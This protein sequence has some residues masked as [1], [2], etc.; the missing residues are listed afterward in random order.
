MDETPGS[1]GDYVVI[2]DDDDP[3]S[4]P[5]L[6]EE[7]GGSMDTVKYT[8]NN[9]L[10]KGFAANMSS[11]CA[12]RLSIMSG[13]KE[14]ERTVQFQS[15]AVQSNAP[16]GLERVSKRGA[17]NSEGKLE[18]GREFT[19][20]FDDNPGEG[21]DIYILDTGVQ[22]DHVDFGGRA[23]FGWAFDDRPVDEN[24][25]GTHCAG[26]AASTNFGVAKGANII[27]VKVLGGDGRGGNDAILGGIDFVAQQHA[28]RKDQP[29]F[30]GSI[31]SMSL[32]SE[33]RSP[34][35]DNAV[36]AAALEG[37]HVSVA[38]GNA[39]S[40]A[41]G[42]SPGF[43]SS[44]S[45]VISVGAIDINDQRADFSNFGA[46]VTTYAPGFRILS[47]FIDPENPGTGGPRNVINAISGTSMAC[48]HVTGLIAYY[49]N[50]FPELATDP[51]G[52]KNLIV[53]ASEPVANL[54]NIRNDPAIVVTNLGQ[55]RSNQQA[56]T[57]VVSNPSSRRRLRGN[58][59]NRRATQKQ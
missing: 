18:T 12:G 15:T 11:H 28:A 52:M 2:V 37:I 21:V 16:W 49:L 25:H 22:V 5:E 56:N 8:Y 46:C 3:R 1:G 14:Y 9:T 31:I 39:G 7:L 29:G 47:T 54:A 53:S 55:L 27:A 51:A 45:S 35:L 38:S 48:P 57:P 59:R 34:A 58:A 24:G 4:I 17:V 20:T 30:K 41:C 19:Y 44:Q 50:K 23:T 33:V 43:A 40:D 13:I 10:F 36:A 26:T 32:G 6:I 42:S